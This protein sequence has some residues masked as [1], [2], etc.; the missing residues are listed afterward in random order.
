MVLRHEGRDCILP[1]PRREQSQIPRANKRFITK[2]KVTCCCGTPRKIRN[3][4]WFDGKIGIWPV[5]DIV[6]VNKG[7][8]KKI[9]KKGI[10]IM[11]LATVN[12]ER[13]KLMIEEAIPAIKAR[14]RTPLGHMN[15][16]QQDGAKAHMAKGVMEETQDAAGDD[17]IPEAQPANSPDLKVNDLGFFQSIQQLKEDVRVTNGGELVEATMEATMEAFDVYPLETLERVWQSLFSVYGEVLGCKGYTSYK[18]PP[19]GKEKFVRAG[20]LPKNAQLDGG[21]CSAGMA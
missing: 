5:V 12:E 13:Y 8:S 16:V 4:L 6:L 3:G 11:K 15:F 19:L 2:H 1:T 14:M 10:P 7:D 17:V 21:K 18:M 9:R 20:N